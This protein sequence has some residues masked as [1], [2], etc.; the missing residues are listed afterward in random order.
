LVL[1]TCSSPELRAATVIRG[2]IVGR[3]DREAETRGRRR[4]RRRR[5]RR[6]RDS[7]CIQPLRN[8]FRRV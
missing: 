4:R 1:H 8:T 5:R 2:G 6:H 7:E 3:Q